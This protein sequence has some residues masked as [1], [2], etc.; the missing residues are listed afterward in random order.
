MD[1]EKMSEEIRERIKK[2]DL[3]M[4]FNDFDTKFIDRDL[5]LNIKKEKYIDN[6]L[7]RDYLKEGII[8]WP[9]SHLER[10]VK[11]PEFQ[12]TVEL[13]VENE[14]R[15]LALLR[16][17]AEAALAEQREGEERLNL[18]EKFKRRS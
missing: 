16:A 18:F 8:V 5:Y 9:E 14:K 17:K 2:E 1:L 11:T 13:L 15:K 3:K 7:S 12:Q 6:E 4:F 10:F